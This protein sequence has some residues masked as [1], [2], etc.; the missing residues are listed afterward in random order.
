MDVPLPAVYG[1][2]VS[3]YETMLRQSKEAN[4]NGEE[5]TVYEGSLTRLFNTLGLSV[6]YYSAVMT[7]LK[8]M[9][10]VEQHRRGGGGAPSVWILKCEPTPELYRLSAPPKST[11]A[12]PADITEQ[13]LNDM[14]KRLGKVEEAVFGG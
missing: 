4:L 12:K 14:N 7:E 13:R 1:H 2:C 11:K 3:V 5:F 6:P 9:D 10:C 8:R